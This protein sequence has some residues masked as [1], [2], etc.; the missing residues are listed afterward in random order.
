MLK[1]TYYS[2]LLIYYELRICR[3]TNEHL[4]IFVMRFDS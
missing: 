2:L 1:Q 4:Q 3:I